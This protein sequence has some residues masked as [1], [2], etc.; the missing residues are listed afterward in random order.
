MTITEMVMHEIK[1]LNKGDLEGVC[2]C[3]TN[4]AQ[5]ID[6]AYPDEPA[7]G[8]DQII[9]A[10]K[11]YFDGFKDLNV[12]VTRTTA[13]AEGTCLAAEFILTGIHVQE[14]AGIPATGKK[15]NIT[16]VSI[17]EYNGEKITK[18]VL[19]KEMQ[20]NLDLEQ[21][22]SDLPLSDYD[23]RPFFKAKG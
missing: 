19:P 16:A 15:M 8:V 12:N 6:A 3:Y 9:E 11:A 10:M 13:N 1:L 4:D 22:L 23:Y 5:M 14:Y 7:V 21:I 20:G 17:Y 2:A 18:E